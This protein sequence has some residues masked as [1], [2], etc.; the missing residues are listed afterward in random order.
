[1]NFRFRLNA[2]PL[3]M[4]AAAA[5]VLLA[6]A[7]HTQQNERYVTVDGAMLGTTV[8]LSAR[9]SMPAGRLYAELMR[10]DT[11]AKA[12]MSVF[13]PASLLNRLNDNRTD[14]LDR[15]IEYNIRLAERISRISG[16]SYDITVK[17]LVEAWGFIRSKGIENP[18]LDSILA[19]VGHD[20]IRIDSGR[21][22]KSDPRV[23]LDL[24]SI[25]KGYTVDMAARMLESHGIGDYI[26]EIGGEIR[27]RGISPRGGDWVVGVDSPT[28][29][30]NEPGRSLQTRLALHDMS[31]ATSGNYRRFRTDASGNKVA[32][33]IDPQ[34]GRSSVSRLL[35]ATVIRPDC[36][37]ADA[38]STMFMAMGDRRALE[39]ARQ[40]DTLALYFIL[41][42]GHG[43]FETYCSTAAKDLIM[44]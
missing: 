35:S 27:C 38:L 23:Q 25:A 43:G 1:M 6:A 9:T 11:L 34:T 5:V 24:N 3:R 4:A 36:A 42:D 15:H 12:S 32:H 20:K 37:E 28:D 31:L 41:D 14:S 30:N 19:F 10:I 21:L 40:A 16:G 13:D 39:F 26:V 33:T 7:C 29:G 44:D 18:D 2:I 22:V 8:H 17:P